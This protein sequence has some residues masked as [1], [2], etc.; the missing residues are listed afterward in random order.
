MRIHHQGSIEAQPAYAHVGYLVASYTYPAFDRRPASAGLAVFVTA[1]VVGLILQRRRAI[2]PRRGATR[3][4]VL[5]LLLAACGG[6]TIGQGIRLRRAYHYPKELT[7]VRIRSLQARLKEQQGAPAE[8]YEW[9]WTPDRPSGSNASSY[10]DAW[11]TRLRFQRLRRAAAD[12]RSYVI[13]SA[14]PDRHFDTPDD[15]RPKSRDLL[16][17]ESAA[18]ER[19]PGAGAPVRSPAEAAPR[20][21]LSSTRGRGH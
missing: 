7:V 17:M 1:L 14:G 10:C 16:L 4:L 5:A 15:I 6:A 19:R 9:S 11:G 20:G 8:L 13:S 21:G 18:P 3:L 12:G 2:R